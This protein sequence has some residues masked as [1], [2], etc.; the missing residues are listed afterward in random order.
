MKIF[1]DF[2]NRKKEP[3]FSERLEKNELIFIDKEY[4]R[5]ATKVLLERA[6][7]LN[8]PIVAGNQD[9]IYYLNKLEPNAKVYPFAKNFTKILFESEDLENGVL[10]DES[11]ASE[12]TDQII[13]KEIMIRGGFE[14]RGN[15]NEQA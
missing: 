3:T 8:I 11:L 15:N 10:I 7:E 5:E 6:V 9:R 1:K 12:L 4:S 2:F 14:L 13:M